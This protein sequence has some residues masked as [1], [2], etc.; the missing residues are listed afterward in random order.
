M[1]H[2]PNRPAVANVR[3][4][5]LTTFEDVAS[6]RAAPCVET[7]NDKAVRGLKSVC[8]FPFTAALH[9]FERKLQIARVL[10]TKLQS[11]VDENS[12]T[13]GAPAKTAAQ[14]RH[15]VR[16]PACDMLPLDLS[17]KSTLRFSSSHP[18]DCAVDALTATTPEGVLGFLCRPFSHKC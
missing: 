11:Y 16:L 13:P 10:S 9:T 15:E 6:T 18:F 12:N 7:D 3:D 5:V 17:L 4:G 2:I 14:A 8:S 1:K